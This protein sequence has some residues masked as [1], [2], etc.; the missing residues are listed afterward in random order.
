MYAAVQA[1]ALAVLLVAL[2]LPAKY[3]RGADLL[4]VVGFYALAKILE[5][6]DRQ[7]FAQRADGRRSHA[8][9]A[10]CRR[11]RLL[12]P[13]DVKEERA[14]GADREASVGLNAAGGEGAVAKV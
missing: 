6:A 3:T 7:V 2:L 9:T 4:G 10:G 5:T 12:D 11:G 14:P 8:E 13:A 1:Y